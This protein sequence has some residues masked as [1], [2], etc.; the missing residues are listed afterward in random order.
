MSSEGCLREGLRETDGSGHP[1][2]RPVLPRQQ[3]WAGVQEDSRLWKLSA[4]AP[5]DGMQMYV[6]EEVQP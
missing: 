3:D 5:F 1:F 4:A 6:N 2:H